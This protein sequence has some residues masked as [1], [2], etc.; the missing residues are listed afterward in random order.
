MTREEAARILVL[1]LHWMHITNTG[2][3]ERGVER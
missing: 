3:I 1:K 2:T